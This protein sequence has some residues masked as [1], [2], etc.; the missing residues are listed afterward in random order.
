MPQPHFFAF[1]ALRFSK[2]MTCLTWAVAIFSMFLLVEPCPMTSKAKG[3]HTANS[4]LKHTLKS[5][6][7][8]RTPSASSDSTTATRSFCHKE[9]RNL[10][11]G[12]FFLRF[13][14]NTTLTLKKALSLSLLAQ[15]SRQSGSVESANSN[16]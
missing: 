9:E 11:C 1:N 2:S 5:G 12:Y 7:F 6:S 4:F 10:L 16:K 15:F 3:W 14:S 13:L 8:M